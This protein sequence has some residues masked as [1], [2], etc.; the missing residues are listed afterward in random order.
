MAT[1]PRNPTVTVRRAFEELDEARSAKDSL[2]IRQ[3]GEKAWLA[4]VEATDRFLGKH[5]VRVPND[6]TAHAERRKGLRTLNRYDL[7]KSYNDLSNSLHGDLF[8]FGE[9]YS[10]AEIDIYFRE[11]AEYVEE[12]TG[13]TG[14]VKELLEARLRRE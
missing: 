13:T 8:Y 5:G 9:E 14:I 12:T 6:E 4:V 2:A 3:A 7:V 11:A 10:A 1:A